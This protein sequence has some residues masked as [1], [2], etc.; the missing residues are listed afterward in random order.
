MAESIWVV[1]EHRDSKIKKI[2]Y[3]LLSVGRRLA[4]SVSAV[5][6]GDEG[7]QQA[8]PL[9]GQ[10]GADKVFVCQ[11]KSL[12]AYT[13]DGWAK[14]LGD[15]ISEHNPWLVLLG[16]TAIGRDL[17]PKLAARFGAGLASDC[18]AVERDGDGRILWTR[19]VYAG[20]ALVTTTLSDAAPMFATLRH[21]V[22]PAAEPDPQKK[23]EIIATNS[24]LPAETIRTVLKQTLKSDAALVDITEANV[25]VTGGRGMK[26]AE[27]FKILEELA[28]VLGGAVGASRAAVDAGWR[29]HQVQVGQT[30]KVV[31][32]ALYIACGVSGSIQ[33]MAGM[34]TS[35]IIVAVNKDPNAPIFKVANYGIVGD[36]FEVVPLMTQEA[37]KLMAS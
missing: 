29:D 25:I 16:A 2:T 7:A 12:S 6:L 4:G 33:H 22:F 8:A 3:E 15:L 30:G 19:P 35:K 5:L 31:S 23:A 9:L 1:A 11:E 10:Y 26:N 24:N 34:K 17:A 28:S 36:L 37:R 20:K 21:N 14:A 13:P 27:N 18:V 32:P